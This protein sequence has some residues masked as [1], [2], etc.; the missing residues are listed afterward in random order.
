M[1]LTP[2]LLNALYELDEEYKINSYYSKA[3]GKSPQEK[4][5][6]MTLEM[7]FLPAKEKGKLMEYY[8]KYYAISKGLDFEKVQDEDFGEVKKHV[9][10]FRIQS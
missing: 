5:T 4:Y 2:K 9:N 6:N 1:K 7:A 8:Y 3:K 10:T